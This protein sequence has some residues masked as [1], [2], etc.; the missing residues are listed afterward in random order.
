[1]AVLQHACSI[2]HRASCV[3]ANSGMN[4]LRKCQ[5]NHPGATGNIQATMRSVN[6]GSLDKKLD[7]IAVSHASRLAE[8]DR[9]A[10][11]LSADCILMAHLPCVRIDLSE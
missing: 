1:L 6:S 11:K 10:R 9:L 4:D 5:R 8:R 2:Q 3:E 7:R